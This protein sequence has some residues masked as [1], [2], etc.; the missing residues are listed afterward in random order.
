MNAEKKNSLLIV[1]D[2][3]S[4]ILALTRILSPEYAIHAAKNGQDAIEAAAEHVPDVI[5]LDILMPEMDG[6]E[7]LAALKGSEKTRAIPVIIVTGLDSP[8]DEEKGLALGA[9]DYIS[10]PFRP[11]S[12]K[13][14]IQNQIKMLNYIDTIKELS[15][16][17]QLTGIP[18]RRSFDERLRLEWGRAIR[19]EAPI[20]ILILDLDNFKSF[21]DTYGHMQGDMVLQTVA[22][23]FAHKLKR[24]VD[25]IAR[26]GGEEF[27][28]LLANTDWSGA[29]D[30]AD[31]M[32]MHVENAVIPLD[33]GQSTKITVS[34]GIN[35]QTPAL[36]DSIGD[37]IRHADK[38]LYTAKKEGRNRV[39]GMTALDDML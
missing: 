4:N 15:F 11:A 12:V 31:G 14:R 29:L 24:A 21:N 7:A 6:Y 5:L 10:K 3:K 1:D 16:I 20:S 26:W 39:C 19:T 25:F 17:D 27:I 8:E 32:R 35:S 38:A 22:K 23:L 37:F 36:S 13:L 34:I 2:E 18:N 33:N 28:A 9:A 30:V